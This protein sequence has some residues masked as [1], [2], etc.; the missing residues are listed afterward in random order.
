MARVALIRVARANAK[1]PH[2]Q[3]ARLLPLVELYCQGME[4]TNSSQ[5]LPSLAHPRIKYNVDQIRD[6]IRSQNGHGN[7]QENAL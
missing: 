1:Q 7:Q 4:Q 5:K 2:P 6:K 3:S